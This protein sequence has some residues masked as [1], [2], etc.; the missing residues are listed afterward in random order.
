MG[1]LLQARRDTPEAVPP[2]TLEQLFSHNSAALQWKS[3]VSTQVGL[4]VL[5]SLSKILKVEA[6]N[7]VRLQF[8]CK[9]NKTEGVSTLATGSCKMWGLDPL[10]CHTFNRLCCF[11]TRA[12]V[13]GCLYTLAQSTD[14]MHTMSA[15]LAT[16]RCVRLSPVTAEMSKTRGSQASCLS[17]TSCKEESSQLLV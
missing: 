12:T 5:T 16:S 2:R 17:D 15:L 7:S 10:V 4:A 13:A 11:Q 3:I 9:G 8:E 1:A 14:H 6:S